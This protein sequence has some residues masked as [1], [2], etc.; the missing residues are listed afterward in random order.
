[1]ATLVEVAPFVLI[2]EYDS[3]IS[4][5]ERWRWLIHDVLGCLPIEVVEE[6]GIMFLD[7][8]LI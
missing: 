5:V 1:M 8:Q 2:E 3:S 7:T 4:R 6:H